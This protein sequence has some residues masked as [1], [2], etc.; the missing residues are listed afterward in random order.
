MLDDNQ[1]IEL[2]SQQVIEELTGQGCVRC[3]ERSCEIGSLA[4]DFV[5]ESGHTLVPVGVSARHVHLTQ[6]HLEILYGPEAT[7]TEFAPLYQPGNFAARETV[8]IVGSRMRAIESV[9]VLGPLRNYSQVE[10][11]GTD[12]IRLGI[13]PPVRE[14]SDLVGA[15][16]ILL[17]GPK[18]SVFLEEGAILANRHIHMNPT[19]AACFGVTSGQP[20]RVR[21]RGDRGLIFE[22]VYIKISDGVLLQM[23]LHTD[24]ANAAGLRGGELVELLVGD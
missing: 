13:D 22:N 3:A 2:I 4:C 6:K 24:D 7:L 15:A 14:S 5:R 17:V 16:P 20:Y 19:D 12:A 21:I 18:G 1:L 9:R 23:H 10:I 11:S 8:T